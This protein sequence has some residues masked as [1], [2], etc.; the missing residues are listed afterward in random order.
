MGDSYSE[1]EMQVT[2]RLESSADI[3]IV[4]SSSAYAYD[5]KE[6]KFLLKKEKPKVNDTSVT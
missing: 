2:P 4:S 3:S 1:I 6:N 5:S